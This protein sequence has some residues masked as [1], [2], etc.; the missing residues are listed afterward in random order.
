MSDEKPKQQRINVQI[1][2]TVAKGVYANA[3]M[4]SHS[5]HELVL[6]FAFVYAAPPRARVEARVVMV[7]K[8]AKR[9]MAAL[10]ENIRRYE[11]TFGEIDLGGGGGDDF[12]H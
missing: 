6:D 1:D 4:V 10:Q 2:E 12:L 3:A 9:L 7:P 5:E 8:Q 11:D